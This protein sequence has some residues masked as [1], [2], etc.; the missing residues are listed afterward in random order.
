MFSHSYMLVFLTCLC[1][2][3]RF[4]I[5]DIQ[6]KFA[7]VVDVTHKKFPTNIKILP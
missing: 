6:V 2:I 7:P 4:F 3:I 1:S 5:V